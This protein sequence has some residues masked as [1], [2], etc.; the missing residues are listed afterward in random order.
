M[1]ATI[2]AYAAHFIEPHGEGVRDAAACRRP[3]NA[4]GNH[5][6]IGGRTWVRCVGKYLEIGGRKIPKVWANGEEPR[7]G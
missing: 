5:L 1:L 6:L 7:R 3:L 2:A 4:Y